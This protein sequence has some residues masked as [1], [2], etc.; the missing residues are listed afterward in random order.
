MLQKLFAAD[1]NT[2]QTLTGRRQPCR[3][4]GAGGHAAFLFPNP[5]PLFFQ[6][7]FYPLFHTSVSPTSLSL[8]RGFR[9]SVQLLL[10]SLFSLRG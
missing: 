10:Q 7:F 3:S 8:F 1:V 2:S 9:V 4:A 6:A 5:A